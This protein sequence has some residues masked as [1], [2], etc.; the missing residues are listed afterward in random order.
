[1]K[2]FVYLFWNIYRF[3]KGKGK[4][5]SA[6]PYFNATMFLGG[7]VTLVVINVFDIVPNAVRVE[8]QKKGIY[9]YLFWILCGTILSFPFRLMF[10]KKKI[11]SLSYTDEEK[12]RYN[13]NAVYLVIGFT[14]L[15][16]VYCFA[17]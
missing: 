8:L 16:I 7:I 13:L 2:T 10:P 9:F 4:T 5:E 3:F 1:M 6:F 12:K 15:T 11:E 14:V 17:M